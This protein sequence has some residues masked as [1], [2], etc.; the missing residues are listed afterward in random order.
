MM[1]RLKLLTHLLIDAFED[2]SPVMMDMKE[3]ISLIASQ[4]LYEALCNS[5]TCCTALVPTV[6]TGFEVD[7]EA[8][9]GMDCVDIVREEAIDG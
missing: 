6:E 9:S 1:Q 4:S 8:D 5:W 3:F 2:V 7:L